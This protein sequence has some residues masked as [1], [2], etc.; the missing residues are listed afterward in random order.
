MDTVAD[1]EKLIDSALMGA[2][3]PPTIANPLGNASREVESRARRGA[4]V[5]ADT[6][7]SEHAT[8]ALSVVVEG[9]QERTKAVGGEVTERETWEKLPK[10]N[11]NAPTPAGV[12]SREKDWKAA[13]ALGGAKESERVALAS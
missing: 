10:A 13:E 3:G 9:A 2:T 5:V 8:G 12:R 7:E 1:N 6:A 4:P 11:E